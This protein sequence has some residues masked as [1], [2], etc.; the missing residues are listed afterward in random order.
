MSETSP[1]DLQL[2]GK[3][4]RARRRV[5]GLTL[6]DVAAQIKVSAGQLSRIETG[7]SAPSFATLARSTARPQSSSRLRAPPRSTSSV[8]DLQPRS[9][10]HETQVGCSQH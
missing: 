3:A 6:Q 10:R 4:L 5:V 8:N 9:M 1:S 2:L 7:R